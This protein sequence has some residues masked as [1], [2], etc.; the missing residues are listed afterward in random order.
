MDERSLMLAHLH[1]L[2]QQLNWAEATLKHA[3]IEPRIW[4]A[5]KNGFDLLF[6]KRRNELKDME[7][8]VSRYGA[9]PHTWKQSGRIS[10]RCSEL[11]RE[12]LGF[13]GSAMIRTEI[14]C[15]QGKPV[16][17]AKKGE[18]CEIADALLCELNEDLPETINWRGVT[19]LA[20]GNFFTETTGLIRLPFPDFG[21]W[22]LPIS[23]HEL[24]HYVGPR[25]LDSY[26]TSPYHSLLDQKKTENSLKEPPARLSEEELEQ[27]LSHVKE[28]FS[29]LF[30]VYALGP[31]Y[32]YSCMLLRFNPGDDLACEDSET[33][34]SYAKR[35]K[36]ILDAL[37]QMDKSEQ[38]PKYGKIRETLKQS[39]ETN[40]KVAGRQPCLDNNDIDSLNFLF[41]KLYLI[42]DGHLS[43]VK[44]QG[45]TRALDLRDEFMA[46]KD[47]A[48][49]LAADYTLADVLNAA[50]L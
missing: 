33:H 35:V 12:C 15:S 48:K 10:S 23:A 20:E 13:L 29:D 39:W 14:I 4:G 31:A 50:W 8:D 40:L 19:L 30:A 2:N 25:I 24:G 34:P 36:F 38:F 16:A 43:T 7:D 47:P 46:D 9:S 5:A 1:A 45:W 27:E 11:F 21:I 3:P 41:S 37:E 22:N 17:R 26:G 6:T 42:V 32:A 44:Y 28:F 49:L 18:I